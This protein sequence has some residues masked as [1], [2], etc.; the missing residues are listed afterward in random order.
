MLNSEIRQYLMKQV[1]FFFL[2]QGCVKQQ[3]YVIRFS[4]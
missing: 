3:N 2:V 1:R 4:E